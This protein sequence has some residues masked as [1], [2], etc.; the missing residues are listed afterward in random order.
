MVLESDH[1]ESGY[2]SV[3]EAA[4]KCRSVGAVIASV[5]TETVRKTVIDLIEPNRVTEC[6][7]L[8]FLD[9]GAHFKIK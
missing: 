4:K 5:E 1:G 9:D 6:L 8:L 3:Y 2:E 7:F